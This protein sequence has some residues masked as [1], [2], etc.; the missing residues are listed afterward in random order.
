MCWW[1]HKLVHMHFL[2]SLSY[3]L[4]DFFTVVFEA[5]V[6]DGDLLSW[7]GISQPSLYLCK[8][9]LAS[10]YLHLNFAYKLI[11]SYQVAELAIWLL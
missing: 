8:C 10:L 6:I 2:I 11:A 5:T 7:V 4:Q 1:L 9:L 3:C